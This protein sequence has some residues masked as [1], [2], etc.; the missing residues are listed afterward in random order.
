M[1][2]KN[3]LFVLAVTSAVLLAPFTNVFAADVS[4]R[5]ATSGTSVLNLFSGNMGGS[6][7]RQVTARF[8]ENKIAIKSGPLNI[9]I[10][11][12]NREVRWTNQKKSVDGSL[13]L[14][15]EK[16]SFTNFRGQGAESTGCFS[17]YST[18]LEKKIDLKVKRSLRYANYDLKKWSQRREVMI[19]RYDIQTWTI[20]DHQ[21]LKEIKTAVQMMVDEIGAV[22]AIPGMEGWFRALLETDELPLLL[23]EISVSKLPFGVAEMRSEGYLAIEE[24]DG[25]HILSGKDT[26]ALKNNLS[27]FE[28]ISEGIDFFSAKFGSFSPVLLSI[29]FLLLCFSPSWAPRLQEFFEGI[30]GAKSEKKNKVRDQAMQ[31]FNYLNSVKDGLNDGNAS[32]RWFANFHLLGEFQNGHVYKKKFTS[33][34]KKRLSELAHFFENAKNQSAH[35]EDAQK[36]EVSLQLLMK[37]CDEIIEAH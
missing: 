25:Q 24:I 23:R 36:H 37:R 28:R 30:G 17:T 15:Q 8:A 18:L 7:E 13:E 27:I 9:V 4:F 3:L 22:P 2:I 32:A 21:A 5:V 11:F 26:I 6:T 19:T 10:D 1:R 20:S 31:M 16:L 14:I 29:T 33:A 12:P 35:A 34:E